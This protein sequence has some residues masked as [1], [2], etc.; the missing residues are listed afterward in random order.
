MT[1]GHEDF[2]SKEGFIL[3][4]VFLVAALG[5]GDKYFLLGIDTLA[6]ASSSLFLSTAW[7]FSKGKSIVR[8]AFSIGLRV[9]CTTACMV[10]IS[11]RSLQDL[12]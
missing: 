7:L 2:F 8:V 3:F 4:L 11:R 10:Q 1:T 5:A 12:F 9:G 6:L